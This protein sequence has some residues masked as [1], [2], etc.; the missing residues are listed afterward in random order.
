MRDK[1]LYAQIL[2]ITYPWFVREV[3]LHLQEGEVIVHLEL[4]PNYRLKG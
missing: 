2:G 1:D 4:D 3:E